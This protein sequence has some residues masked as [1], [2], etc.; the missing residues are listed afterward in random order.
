MLRQYVMTVQ[1]AEIIVWVD[2]RTRKDDGASNHMQKKSFV[3]KMHAMTYC[4]KS[5]LIGI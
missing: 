5:N 1:R 3:V 4:V 2:F